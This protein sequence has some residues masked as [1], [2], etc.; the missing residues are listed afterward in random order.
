MKLR[1]NISLHP[2][3]YEFCKKNGLKFSDMFV[4]G[5]R[6]YR[7][8]G[9]NPQL[10]IQKLLKIIEKQREMLFRLQDMVKEEGGKQ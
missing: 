7:E 2:E 9:G 1:T 6:M 8:S 5:V 10:R 4:L 3:D